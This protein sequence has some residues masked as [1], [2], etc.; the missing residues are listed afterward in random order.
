MDNK[1]MSFTEKS[2]FSQLINEFNNC[3]KL[4][5]NGELKIKIVKGQVYTFYYRLGRIVWATGGSH[6]FRRWR[7]LMAQHCPQ[8]DI[9][10]VRSHFIDLSR[11]YWDYRV[12]ETLYSQQKINREQVNTI[13]ESTIH[14]LLFDLIQQANYSVINYE[15]QQQIILN[16]PMSFTNVQMALQEAQQLWQAW[17]A[18]GLAKFSPNLAPIVCQPEELQQQVSPQIYQK[19]IS[20][21][22]GKHTLRDLA[23]KLKQNVLPVTRSLLPFILKGVIELVEV[24]DL[25]MLQLVHGKNVSSSPPHA[26]KPPLVA[27][28]D[29][30]PQVCQMLEQMLVPNGFRC[31][32]IQDPI[33]ALPNLIQNKPDLIFLDL[34]MP[35]INGYE[36]CTQIRRISTFTNTPIIIL[37]SQDDLLDRIRTRVIG[38]TEFIS[39]PITV[40]K[41]M[42]LIR[43]YLHPAIK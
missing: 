41:T 7:R 9:A 5:Y 17:L 33:Q 24:P 38:A 1:M 6:P 36:M 11:D 40:D 43:K 4:Q 16:S 19:F 15:R 14:E 12:L 26:P 42:A 2:N 22:T 31:L 18:A 35:V 27:C 23:I 28:I 25:P 8:I 32:K 34:I 10:Q 37:T 29:D 21:M 3:I 13:T 39:K 30:S 20:L